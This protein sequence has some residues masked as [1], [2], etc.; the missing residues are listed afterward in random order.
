M[1]VPET[2]PLLDCRYPLKSL[3]GAFGS[4]SNS[5]LP[6]RLGEIEVLEPQAR[7]AAR[8]IDCKKRS[9]ESMMSP[10]R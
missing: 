10:E 9:L 8:G 2:W 4:P 7:S 5:Q 1:I 6:L 3:M